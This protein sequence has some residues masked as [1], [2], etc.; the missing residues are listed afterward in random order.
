MLPW[1][2]L[3]SAKIPGNEGELRLYQRGAEFSIRIGQYELMNS[4][5]Y[6]SEDALG[7]LAAEL[8]G[9]RTGARILIGGLGMGYTLAAVLKGLG[10]KGG[11][12]MAELV[13]AVV[14][15]NRGPLSA[16]AGRPLDDKRVTVVVRDVGNVIG[17][18]AGAYDAI[19]LDVDNGPAALVSKTNDRL[20][21]NRGLQAAFAALRP[22]GF[23]AVWSSNDEPAFT[24]RLRDAGF[25]V[26]LRRVRARG[27]AGGSRYVIWLARRGA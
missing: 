14:T 7:M 3:D 17:A 16:L 4:R 12:V 9:E 10:R 22:H 11:V 13:P 6:G 21:G 26:E 23:L 19:L 1:V 5:M 18:E 27:A 20:Y 2:L 8:V 25:D 24:R 15:W